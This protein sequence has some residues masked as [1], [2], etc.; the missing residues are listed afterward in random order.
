MKYNNR[1]AKNVEK[2]DII[3]IFKKRNVIVQCISTMSK[4]HAPHDLVM[5]LKKMTPAYHS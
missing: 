1:K 5:F 4:F 2:N 3:Q